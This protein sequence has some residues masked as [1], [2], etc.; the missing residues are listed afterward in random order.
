MFCLAGER[1]LTELIAHFDVVRAEKR[2]ND[3]FENTP[4]SKA[5]ATA[6]TEATEAA[7]EE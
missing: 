5:S 7:V 6:S 1:T 2:V 3:N 4:A